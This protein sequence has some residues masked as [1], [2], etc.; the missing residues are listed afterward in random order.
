MP[1]VTPT[2]SP[3]KKA[4]PRYAKQASSFLLERASALITW[5]VVTCI[6]ISIMIQSGSFSTSQ[7]SIAS[8]LCI[9][10]L[11]LW[12]YATTDE[13]CNS[14]YFPKIV[15]TIILFINVIAI[16]FYIPY[17]FVAIFMVMASAIT[18]YYMSIKRSF[19]LSPLWSIP[20][21]LIYDLYWQQDGML[22]TAFLFWT[23][24][25]FGSVMINSNLRE[26]Q[27]RA[28][29]EEANSKLIATQSLLN[30]AVKQSERVRIARNIHDLLG[31]HLT[32]LT[33]NLQVASRKSEGEVKDNIDQCHQLAK[34]LLSDV[35]EAVSEI[36]DKGKLDLEAS[37]HDILRA[38]PTL[39]AAVKVHS[40]VNISDIHI[41]DTI[42]KC[43]Q[44]SITN[45]L[46]HAHGKHMSIELRYL[47]EQNEQAQ[48]QLALT[49]EN[50]GKMPSNISPGNGLKGIKER[51][52]AIQGSA[53]FVLS[54]GKFMTHILIPVPQH[55]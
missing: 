42:I 32:A 44:E 13:N 36:R 39:N 31:H 16:Y 30:E 22:I 41:A 1:S 3:S 26:R 48:P 5:L 9:S 35:R 29:V 14:V 4:A 11:G 52:S 46:K 33:I 18:P 47:S 10:Y 55:D 51:L 38:I 24:N 21:Y 27:A 12:L 7:M 28:D 19:M 15:A 40:N 8:L 23:F 54:S 34:L 6:S 17:S 25:I 49:I 45:T 43:V 20:L 50:D 2:A 53:N 37:I